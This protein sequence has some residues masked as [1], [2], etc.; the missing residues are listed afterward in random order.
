MKRGAKSDR[1]TTDSIEIEID[2]LDIV[3]NLYIGIWDFRPGT[4]KDF[5]DCE[6]STSVFIQEILNDDTFSEKQSG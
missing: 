3:W 4:G 5:Q 2:Y 6:L 1:H